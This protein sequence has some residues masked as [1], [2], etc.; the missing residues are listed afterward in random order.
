MMNLQV[1]LSLDFDNSLVVQPV[2]N[3]LSF[4]DIFIILE[5]SLPAGLCHLS[6]HWRGAAGM[7]ATL[8]SVFIL[9]RSH[10]RLST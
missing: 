4:A 9:A 8:Q 7:F 5:P 1:L 3:F 2:V 6:A 10:P